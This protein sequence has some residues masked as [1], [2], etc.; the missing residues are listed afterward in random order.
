MERNSKDQNRN[1]NIDIM[2]LKKGYCRFATL[3]YILEGSVTFEYND[4]MVT[5]KESDILV[6]NRGTN[7]QY[8][9]ADNLLL[10]S[11]DLAGETFESICDGVKVYVGCNS[12]VESKEYYNQIRNIFKKMLMNQLAVSENPEKRTCMIFEYYSLYYKVLEIITSFFL[13]GTTGQMISKQ[14]DDRNLERCEQIER[15]I[16]I[17]YMEPISLEEMANKFY[18]SKEYFSKYF[19]NHFGMP[20]SLY[21]KQLRLKQAM[22]DLLYTNKTITQISF[23]NGF[24]GSSFFNRAFKE[25]YQKSPSDIRKEFGENRKDV[26]NKEDAERIIQRLNKLLSDETGVVVS[27]LSNGDNSFSV[28]N[29]E[30]MKQCWKSL[31]NIGSA[32]DILKTDIQSH[33]LILSKYINFHYARFWNPFSEELLLDTN[34][35]QDN[36]NFLRFDQVIDTLLSNGLKPFIVFEPKL[37]RINKN[38][39][40]V[41]VKAKHENVIENIC[42]WKSIINATIQHIALKYGIEEMEQWKFELPYEGYQLKNKPAKEGYLQLYKTLS[43][44]ISEYTN[45][46]LLGGPTLP[47][48]AEDILEELLERMK[49]TQYRPGFISMMSFAYDTYGEIHKYS[50]RSTDEDYLLN[51]IKKFQHV[52]EQKGFGEIPIYV[53]EWNQTIVDR[54]YLNDSCYRGAYIVKN[55]IQ[56]N[57]YIS[58]IGYFSGTDLR[59]EYFDSKDILQGGNGLLS[60]DG[61][62]KP[63]GFAFELMNGLGKYKIGTGEN[64]LIT[65]DNRNNYYIMLHNIRKLGYYYYR[66][67]EENIE[68]EK[69][70]KIY[71]DEEKLEEELELKD[72]K[73]GKYQIRIHKVNAQHGSIL[74]LWKELD[75]SDTLSR[76]DI[77]Y[78]QK[79]CEPQILFYKLEVTKNQMRIKICMEPNEFA[80]IE[81]KR[82]LI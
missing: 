51:S 72:I 29:T 31:V 55:L 34:N 69:I 68:K 71:E 80:L 50:C 54:N 24:S 40:T 5:L 78:L 33:I 27:E 38:I 32:A 79:I 28:I 35:E 41:I 11:L 56:V 64:F 9:G 36:Y 23:D 3:F 19:T 76:K 44:A 30:P 7:Y 16:K 77:M 75:Y 8:K 14:Q 74:D 37:E 1:I 60:R 81:V 47:A 46:P 17:H 63:A 58:M 43:D 45:I 18:I 22:G 15:Y 10:A 4:K 61:I 73:N 12:T 62:F 13:V 67:M 82:V 20:F 65:S 59:T 70:P 66:T 48:D 52:L 39:D 53:T 57:S 49:E 21:L 25:K 26:Q 2:T 6:I 42:S